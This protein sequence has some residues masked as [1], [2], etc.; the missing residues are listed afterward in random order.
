MWKN[1]FNKRTVN[2][3]NNANFA[4]PVFT[5]PGLVFTSG[6]FEFEKDKINI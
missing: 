2:T 6:T 4:S 1:N 3:N 5:R